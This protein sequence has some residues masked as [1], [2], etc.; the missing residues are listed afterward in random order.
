MKMKA[1]AL[2][3]GMIAGKCGLSGG[4]D[5]HEIREALVCFRSTLLRVGPKELATDL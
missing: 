3:I 5:V 1:S 2:I 4:A